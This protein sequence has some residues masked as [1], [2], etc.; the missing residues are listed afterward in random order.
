MLQA[1]ALAIVITTNAN[2]FT[3]IM[4]RSE[5]PYKCMEKRAKKTGEFPV[6]NIYHTS[7]W[8]FK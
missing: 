1:T 8:F 4:I 7:V 6:A 2:P 3:S 5:K